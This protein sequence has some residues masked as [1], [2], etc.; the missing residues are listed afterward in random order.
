M[1]GPATPHRRVN[2]GRACVN[3]RDFLILGGSAV[4]VLATVGEGAFE[5]QHDDFDGGAQPLLDARD[6]VSDVAFVEFRRRHNFDANARQRLLNDLAF[7]HMRLINKN[8]VKPHQ[9][10]PFLPAR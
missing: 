2:K 4:T 10:A 7:A 8:A 1:T 3:R 9:L 6:D 5:L